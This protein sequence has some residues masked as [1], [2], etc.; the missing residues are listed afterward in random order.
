MVSMPR[1]TYGSSD[2]KKIGPN[3]YTDTDY[4]WMLEKLNA[5]VNEANLSVMRAWRQA[6]GGTYSNNPFNTTKPTPYSSGS[7]VKD[8]SNRKAGL[9]ANVKTMKLGYYTDV[10]DSL[11]RSDPMGAVKSIVESPWAAGNYGSAGSSWKDSTLYDVYKSQ[12][13]QGVPKVETTTFTPQQFATG[14]KVNRAMGM[15][16]VKPT[17]PTSVSYEP[18]K[19]YFGR[20]GNETNTDNQPE[21]PKEIN[22]APTSDYKS[23]TVQPA[24][25]LS[26]KVN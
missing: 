6:E 22:Y 7:F 23:E 4:A 21:E 2:K 3:D 12:N 19:E 5:P 13:P 8:Y 15:G 14:T 16:D 11:R 26:V 17:E 10:V 9:S 18:Y 20:I 1:P 24:T 25:G